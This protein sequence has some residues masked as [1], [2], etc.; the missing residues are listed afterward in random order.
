MG[1]NNMANGQNTVA[2]AIWGIGGFGGGGP[3]TSSPTNNYYHGGAGGG[4]YSGGSGDQSQ[5]D[6]GGGGGSYVNTQL[7]YYITP[8]QGSYQTD[9]GVFPGGAE[10]GSNRQGSVRVQRS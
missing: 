1:W 5:Y 4:G 2:C 8:A 7:S 10:S 9:M 6:A 3:A